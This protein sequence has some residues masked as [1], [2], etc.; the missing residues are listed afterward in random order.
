MHTNSQVR[1]LSIHVS[2]LARE[3]SEHVQWAELLNSVFGDS[4]NIHISSD[5]LLRILRDEKD[6]ER[7]NEL[8]RLCGHDVL[9][10]R[11]ID[12]AFTL[13]GLSRILWNIEECCSKN[14]SIH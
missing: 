4:R 12:V 8:Y 11:R 10:R 2:A 14:I 7:I 5:D 1:S 3:Q 13:V 6:G 9:V